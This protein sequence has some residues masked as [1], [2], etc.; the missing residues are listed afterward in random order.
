MDGW[1]IFL[2]ICL[3]ILELALILTFFKMAREIAYIRDVLD[4]YLVHRIDSG[5]DVF[6]E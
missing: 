3:A 5:K 1:I 4:E 6:D 2:I